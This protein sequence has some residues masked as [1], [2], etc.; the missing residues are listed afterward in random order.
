VRVS[1]GQLRDLVRTGPAWRPPPPGGGGGA[2][3]AS[4]RNKAI[5]IY[6]DEGYTSAQSYLAGNRGDGTK[7]LAGAFGVG[8]R[9]HDWGQRT[10]DCLNRYFGQDQRLGEVYAELPLRG[11]V[12]IGNHSVGAYVDVVVFHP[13]GYVGRL[14]NW[15]LDG[16]TLPNADL[17]AVPAAL[18]IEQELGQA[19]C[20]KIAVWDLE[21][22][23]QFEVSGTYALGQTAGLRALL[24]RVD[25]P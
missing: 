10:R 2:S 23:R 9:Y 12:A 6:H 1:A 16:I 21:H 11:D 17:M 19:T 3:P 20:V 24:D 25:P 7:G 14:L 18:L 8:G 5:A 22:N 4:A 15:D 13:S